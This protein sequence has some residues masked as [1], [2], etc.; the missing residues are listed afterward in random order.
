VLRS[1]PTNDVDGAGIS[2][3]SIEQQF[4]LWRVE[5]WQR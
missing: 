2:A 1:W 3:G 4:S 5:A